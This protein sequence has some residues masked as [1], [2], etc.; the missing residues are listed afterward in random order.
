MTSSNKLSRESPSAAHPAARPQT[1]GLVRS[2]PRGDGG[3]AV[4]EA[5]AAQAGHQ[6]RV[7]ADVVAADGH[8]PELA[9]ADERRHHQHG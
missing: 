5:E 3:F 9:V 2:G 6:H 4:G 8:Q 1:R 7:Q